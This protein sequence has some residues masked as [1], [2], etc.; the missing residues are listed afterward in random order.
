MAE[1]QTQLTENQKAYR[2][3]GR[4]LW[5]TVCR[6]KNSFQEVPSCLNSLMDLFAL[7]EER[8]SVCVQ[9][10]NDHASLLSKEDRKSVV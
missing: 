6:D 7:S 9:W 3:I 8:G 2:V 1:A 10:Q 5:R 4:A